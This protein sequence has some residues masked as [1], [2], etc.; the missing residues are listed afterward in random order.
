LISDG[1]DVDKFAYATETLIRRDTMTVEMAPR[2]GFVARF[3]RRGTADPDAH[4]PQ[5]DEAPATRAVPTRPASPRPT[6]RPRRAP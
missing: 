6:G 1:E 4:T 2:G 5:P 3:R